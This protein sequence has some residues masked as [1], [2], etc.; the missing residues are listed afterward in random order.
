MCLLSGVL[1]VEG[2]VRSYRMRSMDL[3]TPLSA[4]LP[5]LFR[6]ADSHLSEI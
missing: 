3:S 1:E 5:Y 6:L 2:K 4:T